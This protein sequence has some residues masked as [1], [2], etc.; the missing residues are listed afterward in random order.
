MCL[1]LL[2]NKKWKK[3]SKIT[4][5]KKSSNSNF[6]E[7]EVQKGTHNEMLKELKNIQGA[8]TRIKQREKESSIVA[9]IQKKS[10]T[11][12]LLLKPPQLQ[13]RKTHLHSKSEITRKKKA[14]SPTNEL[15]SIE[16]CSEKILHP[17]RPWESTLRTPNNRLSF[18]KQ[19]SEK[20]QPSL[21]ENVKNVQN[22]LEKPAQS[23]KKKSIA[24]A[25]STNSVNN[26]NNIHH[27]ETKKILHTRNEDIKPVEV[28]MNKPEPNRP[29][30]QRK[31]SEQNSLF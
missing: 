8:L 28:K 1:K 12:K 22:R 26:N 13:E 30:I 16:E 6:R 31:F 9:H 3:T 18:P 5:L 15:L 4:L 14:R 10:I 19:L 17:D 7:K 27:V 21:F 20:T 11:E 29:N 24:S 2:F 25:S 23:L